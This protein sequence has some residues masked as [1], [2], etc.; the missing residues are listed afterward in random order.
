MAVLTAGYDANTVT[1]TSRGPSASIWEDCPV[2]L[3]K[4]QSME[5]SG[6]TYI[7]ED[8]D[9][10][11]EPSAG[12]AIA[13]YGRFSS[14]GAAGTTITDAVEEGGVAKINGTTANKSFILSSNAGAFRFLG[15][16]TG[17]AY[18]GGKFWMEFRIALGSIA[19][20]QQGVFVGLADN[21]S[22]QINSSDTTII[23][24]G[25]NTLTTTKNLFGFFNRATTGPADFSF[26]Y[27]PAAGTAVYPTGLTALV[28]NVTGANIAAYAASTDKGQGTGFVKI[29]M[30]YDPTPSNGSVLAPS[31]PPSGQT[32]GTLYKPLFRFY[33][34]GLLHAKFINPGIAQAAA[35]PTNAVFSPVFNYMNIAGGTAP[36]YLDWL[37]FAQLPSF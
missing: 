1:N 14:W 10:A 33:V 19:A 6:G 9:L 12:A 28:N 34:N 4:E 23:A 2:M 13:S 5:G 26:V 37:R 24:S 27:Q 20:S 22:S 32:A 30:L 17:Y 3:I 21:T 31:S 18:T 15:G 8:F 11:P 25:G 16:S 7:W 35:F 29:G 36:V